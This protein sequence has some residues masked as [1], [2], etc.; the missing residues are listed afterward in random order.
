[1]NQIG[2]KL[3]EIRIQR[4]LSLREAAEKV[5]ISHTYLSALERGRDARTGRPVNPSAKTLMRIA[6]GYGIA[7][8]DLLR[9]ATGEGVEETDQV[10]AM[11]RTLQSLAP[12]DQKVILYLIERLSASRGNHGAKPNR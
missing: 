3:R 4:R 6:N 9:L 2:D 12:E 8:Q 10:E 5:G 11:A 7:A 1:M